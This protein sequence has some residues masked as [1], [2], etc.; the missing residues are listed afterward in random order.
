MPIFP[1]E[2]LPSEPPIIRLNPDYREEVE[3]FYSR[4]YRSVLENFAE[5]E[6]KKVGWEVRLSWDS[7]RGLIGIMSGIHMGYDLSES[8]KF[9]FH[10]VESPEYQKL[11]SSVVQEYVRLLE[12]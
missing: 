7:G 6:V 2:D 4:G 3:R 11:F 10:N 9:M 1:I 8:G 5:E 12:E